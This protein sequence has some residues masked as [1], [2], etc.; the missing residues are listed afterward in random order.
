MLK[1][2][3]EQTM[4]KPK[5]LSAQQ[6][7]SCIERPQDAAGVFAIWLCSGIPPGS[8]QCT[9]R[10]Y[11]VAH[12]PEDDAEMLGFGVTNRFSISHVR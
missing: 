2:V 12:M 5:R 10:E 7:S 9:W 3:I 8:E 11:R 6:P 4:R 1:R